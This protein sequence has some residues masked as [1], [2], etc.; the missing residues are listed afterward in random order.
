MLLFEEASTHTLCE[1][2]GVMEVM[3]EQGKGRESCSLFQSHLIIE[4]SMYL[5]KPLLLL[6]RAYR[7]VHTTLYRALSASL[8]LVYMDSFQQPVV[9]CQPA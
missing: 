5:A 8:S 3:N 1:G 7:G 2:V 9:S 4:S 6:P